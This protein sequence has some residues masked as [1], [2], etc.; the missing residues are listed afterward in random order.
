MLRRPTPSTRLENSRDNTGDIKPENLLV[1]F[2]RGGR[3]RVVLA[4]FGSACE[5][6][7]DTRWRSETGSPFWQSPEAW[8]LD[9]DYRGDVYSCGVVLL[10]LTHGMLTAGESRSRN[11]LELD[12][13]A[14]TSPRRRAAV[15][16]GV[17]SRRGDSFV[18]RRRA[19]WVIAL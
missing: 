3:A 6:K 18:A 5:Y 7:S 10:V 1:T 8:A 16:D 19:I 14:T 11:E 4:D 17:V 15:H 12:M 9:Y 13:V 2:E